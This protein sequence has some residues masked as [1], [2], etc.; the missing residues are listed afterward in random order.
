MWCSAR[1]SA[2]LARPVMTSR[3]SF[4]SGWQ[5]WDDDRMS[6]AASRRF[7]ASHGTTWVTLGLS[8]SI[9]LAGCTGESTADPGASSDA[10]R[11]SPT[12]EG[13]AGSDTPPW[14]APDQVADR[15]AAAGLDLGLMGM[16]EH[17]HPQLRVVVDGAEV[18]VPANIGV[19]PSTG[20][21]SALHTH[22]PDGQLH[23]E[24]DVA[25]EVFTLG[26]LFTQW[27]VALSSEQI[28]GVL[29][30]PGEAVT[31]TSNG[32]AFTGDPADLRLEPDQQI[33][34]E[35]S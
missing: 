16:A 34:V 31:V 7:S 13:S 28:G 33:V 29:A 9:V 18:A 27:G 2:E 19:D 25:G 35:V 20:A 12:V 14:P 8:L 32:A 10:P 11:P 17:Y 26:Q 22:T 23:V 30:K 3:S 4:E 1:K 21:M 6:P 5:R 15:V 24:A